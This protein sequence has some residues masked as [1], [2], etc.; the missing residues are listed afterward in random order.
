LI[1]TSAARSSKFSLAPVAMADTV[2]MLAGH[3]TMRSGAPEPLATGEV[4]S[5]S[6]NTRNCPSRA[7]YS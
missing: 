3:T 6:P 4:H 2:A 7:P 1:T 5:S